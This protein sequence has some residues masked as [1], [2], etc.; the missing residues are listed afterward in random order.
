[1]SSVARIP[2]TSLISPDA[3]PAAGSFRDIAAAA[4]V[5]AAVA[6]A[7]EA[8]ADIAVQA[9]ETVEA[10]AGAAAPQSRRYRSFR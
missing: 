1:M 4:V 8:E 2:Q 7:A 3:A 5:G 10:A 9:A 6:I